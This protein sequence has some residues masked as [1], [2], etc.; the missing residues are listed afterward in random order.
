MNEPK[1]RDLS[2]DLEAL[3]AAALAAAD[4][5]AA[6]RRTLG[7]SAAGFRVGDQ[8]YPLAPGARLWLIAVG[9]ASR[10]MASGALAALGA[11]I[12]GGVIVHPHGVPIAAGEPA[13]LPHGLDRLAAGHPL[14]DEGSLAAGEAIWRL[15]DD[16]GPDD[17]LLVLLSGG[18]SALLESPRRGLTLEALRATT[19]ALQS[20]GADVEELNTVR[21]A[22]SRI[23]GGGLAQRA[24]PARVVTLALSDVLGDRPEAIGSGPTVPSPTGP[25]D[26]LA[27]L[28]RTGVAARVPEAVAALR[29]A[30]EVR[31]APAAAPRHYFL[32]GS[33]RDAAAAV[34][35]V[36]RARG[37][38][39]EIATTFL[40]G[41]AREVGRA[42]GGCALSVAAH[43]LPFAPPACLI[44][45]GETTVTVRGEGRGGRNQEL[46]LGAA[47]AIAGAAR[48][49]VFSFATD[50]VDG[51]SEAAGAVATGDTLV[52]A[53]ALGLSARRALAENDSAPF[54]AALGDAW[55][56]GPTG[57][58]VND[59]AL[60]LVYA[61]EPEAPRGAPE[62]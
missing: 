50:G 35:G 45:G 28:E 20:A 16:S 17:L 57:T 4:P 24:A 49:A 23:K 41:E 3:H 44:F 21:R 54:F 7:A 19:A 12:S 58:N 27:L 5:I 48:V 33:N 46:A 47:L 18:A 6:V 8:E 9:K 43:A 60:A 29:A 59:L 56:S 52:R 1:W 36:A 39:A 37:F 51:N 34:A 11:R 40:Q 31:A 25:R 30:A 2:A 26:A 61:D 22:L 32:V 38:R 62:R 14:P 13:V 42:I 15:L 53:A 55:R 10:G